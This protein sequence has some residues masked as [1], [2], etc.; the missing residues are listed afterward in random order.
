RE[1]K[2]MGFSDRQLAELRDETEDEVRHR[3]WALGVRPAYKMV[4][5]CAGEFPS[6][7]PYLYS[8][9]DEENESPRSGRR[10]VVILGSGPN[11]IGQGVEFDYCC[12][13]AAMAL[14][15]QGFETIMINSNPETVSTDFDT[16]DKLYFEPLTFDDV[17]EVIDRE[18]AEG[19]I[20]QLG[21]QT[22][23]KLTRR[24]EAAGVHILGTTPDAIDVAEDR[25]RFEQI[26]R[27]LGLN[28]APNG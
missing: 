14:R 5:T 1:M 8:S 9:Y 7:T 10:S 4:D 28:Q 20:V 25:R 11:R 24:L 26:A 13:R 16:S 19:V 2:R 18:Q 17:L 15:Q 27:E 6:A 22:P 23:L 3:R 21:G 12:V